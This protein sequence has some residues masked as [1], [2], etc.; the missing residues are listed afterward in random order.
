M[1]PEKIEKMELPVNFSQLDQLNTA[2]FSAHVSFSWQ[3]RFVVLSNGKKEVNLDELA[4]AVLILSNKKGSLQY[5]EKGHEILE[6]LRTLYTFS[7]HSL[8]K[9]C[10][11]RLFHRVHLF[12]SRNNNKLFTE[13]FDAPR[14]KLEQPNAQ[15]FVNTK[16]VRHSEPSRKEAEKSRSQPQDFTNGYVAPANFGPQILIPVDN[17]NRRLARLAVAHLTP[18]GANNLIRPSALDCFI[19]KDQMKMKGTTL[20]L[21]INDR[22]LVKDFKAIWDA[23]SETLY[24]SGGRMGIT[25][26]LISSK[27]LCD[28]YTGTRKDVQYQQQR[29]SIDLANLLKN[30]REILVAQKILSVHGWNGNR[31]TEVSPEEDRLLFAV[32]KSN[33]QPRIVFI[34]CSRLCRSLKRK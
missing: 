8:K 20:E 5:Q 26:G 9:S 27:E 22:R 4:R 6:R 2:L 34:P 15:F 30:R 19:I 31:F 17:S 12:K 23:S 33:S 14:R 11:A 7:D 29:F 18:I 10:K 32:R 24:L 25:G 28:V 21:C 3:G 16:L 13:P 1:K